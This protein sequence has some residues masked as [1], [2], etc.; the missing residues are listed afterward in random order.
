MLAAAHDVLP[1]TRA[2]LDIT[3]EAGVHARVAA[4]GAGARALPL[5]RV[6]ARHVV[7]GDQGA[8]RAPRRAARHPRHHPG[9]AEP[10]R[11]AAPLLRA[12]EPQ[13]RCGRDGDAALAGRSSALRRYPAALLDCLGTPVTPMIRL[14]A[15]CISVARRV[16]SQVRSH[17]RRGFSGV[18]VG[19]R[20][21]PLRPG[22]AGPPALFAIRMRRVDLWPVDSQ[23]LLGL[24]SPAAFRSRVSGPVGVLCLESGHET[25]G[26]RLPGLPCALAG[27]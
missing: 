10:A 9:R 26:S 12:V 8:G 11:S 19:S 15:S 18:P 20:S 5:R 7:R 4:G 14:G 16:S 17:L 24:A 25:R 21:V 1:L 27:S 6:G 22:L 3:D 2:D 23:R 13:A